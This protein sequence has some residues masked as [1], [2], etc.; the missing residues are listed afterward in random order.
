M[1]LAC[2][3]ET[4]GILAGATPEEAEALKR[5]GRYFGIAFQII[6]DCLDFTGEQQ[7]FGKTLGAD[8]A[9]GVLTLPLIRLIQLVEEKTKGEVFRIFSATNLGGSAAYFGGKSEAGTAH[10]FQTLLAMIREYGT[11]Q[12]SLDR[13]RL[14]LSIFPD[15]A[16]RRSLERLLDYVISRNR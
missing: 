7:E 8:C 2:S 16:G 4:G 3:L 5:V 11:I 10:K 9:A 14:E 1:L 15:N 12:Y 13:A 6:D